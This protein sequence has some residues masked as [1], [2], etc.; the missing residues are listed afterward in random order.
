MRRWSCVRKRPEQH[1]S[2]HPE[3]HHEGGV[4]VLQRQ[5]QV[6]AAAAGAGD[7]RVEQ[8]RG[9][10]GGPGLVTAHRAGVMH[11]HRGDA[12]TRNVRLQS[13]PNDLD[14]GQFR[15]SKR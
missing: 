7:A 14:F 10:V 5:P 4:A 9:E 1:L 6:L 3:M 2:A 12:F 15:H 11:P 13:P 8:P